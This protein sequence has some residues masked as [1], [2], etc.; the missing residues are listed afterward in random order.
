MTDSV[1]PN[2]VNNGGNASP[3]N[4]PS[5]TGNSTLGF[6]PGAEPG[7][8]GYEGKR[9][10]QPFDC[11]TMFKCVN[12]RCI[13]APECQEDTNG[14]EE[15]EGGCLGPGPVPTPDP[16]VPNCGYGDPNTDLFQ[17]TDCIFNCNLFCDEWQKI[18][19][20]LT[21]D[22]SLKDCKTD[23]ACSVC[24]SCQPGPD[25]P[26][27]SAVREAFDAQIQLL[28]DQLEERREEQK[29]E[30]E[31]LLE[32]K[33][34]IIEEKKEQIETIEEEIV[35]LRKDIKE[36]RE[37]LR[38]WEELENEEGDG[39]YQGEIDAAKDDIDEWN[40]E[41]NELLEDIRDI[42]D[43]MRD[44]E[45]L[46]LE[47]VTTMKDNHR[48]EI[49]EWNRLISE[50]T[51]EKNKR[52]KRM[53]NRGVCK[54]IKVPDRPCYCPPYI[55][56]DTGKLVD[57]GKG[58][59]CFLCNTDNG[60]W[61]EQDDLCTISCERCVT[62]DN[63]RQ[64]CASITENQK[65]SFDICVRAR[66]QA[67]RKCGDLEDLEKLC[68]YPQNGCKIE[69]PLPNS[70]FS[71]NLDESRELFI[72]QGGDDY[73]PSNNGIIA[74]V[75]VQASAGAEGVWHLIPSRES[76]LNDN[77]G[78]FLDTGKL[79]VGDPDELFEE[80]LEGRPV[81]SGKPEVGSEIIV[82]TEDEVFSGNSDSD[83]FEYRWFVDNVP[84]RWSE[85][86]FPP[87]YLR[88][89]EDPI[90]SWNPGNSD[91]AWEEGDLVDSDIL[92]LS[93]PM[94]GAYITV[95]VR[96]K[97][98]GGDYD[99]TNNEQRL[100]VY[101]SPFGIVL[102]GPDDWNQAAE[103]SIFG[104]PNTNTYSALKVDTSELEVLYYDYYGPPLIDW[105]SVETGQSVGAGDYLYM[106]EWAENRSFFA[107]ATFID[108]LGDPH[109]FISNS[110]GPVG[111]GGPPDR[112]QDF[113][114]DS[115]VSVTFSGD[116]RE[117]SVLTSS[118]NW[119]LANGKSAGPFY[120]W[121]KN[122][123]RIF[124]R[125]DRTYKVTSEDVGNYISAG[126]EVYDD[127][128]NI[129]TG[130]TDL[131]GDAVRNA[132]D[133]PTGAI[134]I[135]GPS[136]PREGDT[137]KVK[138]NIV[139]E[140]GFGKDENGVLQQIKYLW[141]SNG[142]N[143][144]IDDTEPE[145][146]DKIDIQKWMDV[147]GEKIRVI[148]YYTD[149]YGV[150]KEIISMETKPVQPG[151][152]EYRIGASNRNSIQAGEVVGIPINLSG[153]ASD[154]EDIGVYIRRI[155]HGWRIE[156][157][158]GSGE[159]QIFGD[160]EEGGQSASPGPL[161]AD[162]WSQEIPEGPECKEGW[163]CYQQ[164]YSG[165]QVAPLG[166]YYQYQCP[167]PGHPE[168]TYEES[169]EEECKTLCID[170]CYT[171]NL[172]IGANDPPPVLDDATIIISIHKIDGT[173]NYT[174][175]TCAE[176]PDPEKCPPAFEKNYTAIWR[177]KTKEFEY[178]ECSCKNPV[179]EKGTIPSKIEYS[180]T[181]PSMG[182]WTLDPEEREFYPVCGELGSEDLPPANTDDWLALQQFVCL[183]FKA[184]DLGCQ[185]DQ[186][187]LSWSYE[188]CSRRGWFGYFTIRRD[189]FCDSGYKWNGQRGFVI[190]DGSGLSEDGKTENRKFVQYHGY[191]MWPYT[192]R[193]KYINLRPNTDPLDASGFWRPKIFNPG[194]PPEAIPPKCVDAP[195]QIAYYSIADNTLYCTKEHYIEMVGEQWYKCFVDPGEPEGGWTPG[196]SPCVDG[197]GCGPQEV[198]CEPGYP[199]YTIEPRI[200]FVRGARFQ[201][202]QKG[203]QLYAGGLK[204]VK[205]PGIPEREADDGQKTPTITA[206]RWAQYVNGDNRFIA[207]LKFALNG[208]DVRQVEAV[209]FS[210]SKGSVSDDGNFT[211]NSSGQIFARTGSIENGTYFLGFQA[212]YKNLWS[213]RWSVGV[214]VFDY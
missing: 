94:T 35:D 209:R 93:A 135:S 168:L 95:G 158:S 197:P 152:T 140:D 113:E 33:D 88:D 114:N 111:I 183:P 36:R 116:Y 91:G 192:Y 188:V 68:P 72:L 151:S 69:G 187:P 186:N 162:V 165:N 9:C 2:G 201:E 31:E 10:I 122:T 86:M 196:S 212:K 67:Q 130:I 174:L 12:G 59:E 75:Y 144:E 190:T 40:E 171:W 166:S 150:D 121:Y 66:K 200:E 32:E 16:D 53:R 70:A 26:D 65:G 30:L 46:Y 48:R 89:R 120:T 178:S 15:P 17:A 141:Q 8:P 191:S 160:P 83:E 73:L 107:V 84:L 199:N 179:G 128:G 177:V 102:R 37:E 7:A 60:N 133:Q 163:D 5:V 204:A 176:P 181:P 206:P 81:I 142:Y 50:L 131:D 104:A 82:Q 132:P 4:A 3:V 105:I 119:S 87:I 129:F 169:L 103:I 20:N 167:Y 21:S 79:A 184:F 115:E 138:H 153:P 154:T 127:F 80:D 211:V 56:E 182:P 202:L 57:D 71:F 49:N 52:L 172:E 112:D 1:N 155:I 76:Y 161:V 145:K 74:I 136:D 175:Q 193:N 100:L 156:K 118:A 137:L 96:L 185:W 117:D 92:V 189:Y 101:S 11:G 213:M 214:N 78:L 205:P 139:D 134:Y 124:G 77:V 146:L 110:I 207:Q 108:D 14:C 29:E 39:T 54:A 34:K 62:C 19:A 180:V 18:S 47:N 126:A 208:D 164:A 106:R 99:G 170:Y 194:I 64:A 24:K 22:T 210:S 159:M 42:R 147:V 123:E 13:P 148:A 98:T 45:S 198:G 55:D 143:I 38:E 51:K 28:Y 149:D 85:E 61:E 27:I 25:S 109:T 58:R 63:G 195:E 6:I 41:I 97:R 125:Y 23:D 90:P 157:Q 44:I 203:D 173:H 43:E